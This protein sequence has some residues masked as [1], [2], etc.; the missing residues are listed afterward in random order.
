MFVIKL[1]IKSIMGCGAV[2]ASAE[3][4]IKKSNTNITSNISRS[5]S[6]LK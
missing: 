6:K 2:S 4:K 3:P 5:P 1:I